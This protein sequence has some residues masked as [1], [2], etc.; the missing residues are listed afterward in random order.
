MKTPSTPSNTLLALAVASALLAACAS[1]P[2][3]PSGADALRARLSQL[4]SNAE[5]SSRAPLAIKEADIAVTAA[6]RPQSDVA[7]S[8]HLLF[9]ADRKIDVAQALGE[10]RLAVDQRKTLEENRESMRLQAR[11]NEADSANLRATT[12]QADAANQKQQA[13][14]ARDATADAQRNAQDLQRQIDELHAKN[15]DRGL[16]LTLGDVLFATNK[17]T[18][19]AGGTANLVKLAGFLAKYPARNAAIE[20]YTDNVGS[21]AYNQELSQR[22]ADAVKSY[23]MAQGVDSGR[24]TSAGKGESAPVSDNGSSTGRQQNRRVEVIIANDQAS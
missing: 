5:L 12:A 14:S 4:Q 3:K 19:N 11:T 10:G 13:D 8:K 6:E 15:T 18:L 20:G 16:V 7:L 22:R 1:A 17:S 23:L 9:M 2:I 21:E 24:L